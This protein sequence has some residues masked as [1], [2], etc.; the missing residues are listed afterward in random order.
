MPI[1]ARVL[2]TGML[3]AMALSSQAA[4]R[5]WQSSEFNC[6]VSLPGKSTWTEQSH[7]D[8]RVRLALLDEKGDRG[9]VVMVVKLPRSINVLK[10]RHIPEFEK[11]LLEGTK[12]KIYGKKTEMCG[13]PAYE[14]LA[15]SDVNCADGA[16]REALVLVRM[17]VAD[18]SLYMVNCTCFA[19]DPSKDVETM[20]MLSSFRFLKPP[21]LEPEAVN[22]IYHGLYLLAMFA[23]L[24]FGF[25]WRKRSIRKAKQP[26]A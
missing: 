19:G 8:P 2:H 20:E 7:P 5:E 23:C 15:R 25:W 11:T 3:L 22:K 14:V 9:F 13:V 26:G 10:D 21:M 16:T 24:C 12:E 1:L 6:G 18:G 17:T 4:A